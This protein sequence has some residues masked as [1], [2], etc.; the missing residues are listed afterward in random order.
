MNHRQKIREL[1]ADLRRKICV[2]ASLN[3]DEIFDASEFV[4]TAGAHLDLCLIAEHPDSGNLQNAAAVLEDDCI[5]FNNHLKKWYKAFCIAHEIGHFLLHHQSLHCTPEEIDSFIEGGETR[6]A[7]EKITGYGAGDRRER[8]A[9]LFALEL[10]LPSQALRKAYLEQ[11]LKAQKISALSGLPIEI[12]FGQLA[13]TALV[14]FAEKEELSAAAGKRELNPSQKQAAETAKCPTL[15]YA[16]PGTGKT[17]TLIARIAHLINRGTDPKRILALTFSNKAAEEMRERIEKIDRQAAAQ[18]QVMTFHAYG[19]DIL[20]AYWLEAGLDPHT[21]LV[22]KIDALLHLESNLTALKLDHYQNLHEPTQNLSAVLAAISRAKDELC[23]PENYLSLGEKMLAEA[24]GKGDEELSLKARKVIETAGVYR[25]Y[26]NYLRAEK[27]LDFGDLVYRAVRLL[28]SNERVKKE[29]QGKYDAVLVDEFQDVNRACGVLLKEIAGNGNSLWTVGDLRQSIYRWR[30]ASPANIERFGVDFPQAETISL[31]SNYRSRAEIVDLFSAFAGKMAAS[32]E[33]SFSAWESIRGAALSKTKKAVTLTIADSL[34][35]EAADIARQIENLHVEQGLR[36]KDC[37]VICRTHAQL[38][39]FAEVLSRQ[40]IPIFYLGELFEREEIRDLLALLDVKITPGSHSLIRVAAFPEY[41]IPLADA[42]RIIQA[43][44][45]NARTCAEALENTELFA[46]L[47]A[48]GRTGAAKLLHHLN[49][50]PNEVS[51]WKYLARYLF[52]ESEYLTTLFAAGEVNNQ[53]KR[54]AVYQFLRLAESADRRF[55]GDSKPPVRE[56]L[57]YVVKLAHFN[58]DKNYAQIPAEAENLDAVRL[59][60]VHSAKG[61]EFPAVFLPYLGAGKFPSKRNSQTCPN[62]DGMIEHDADFH[63]AEEECLFFVAMS[64]ARDYLHLSR[65]T[66][67][68]ES[69]SNESKFLK[70]LA[71]KLPAAALVETDDSTTEE[72]EISPTAEIAGSIFYAAELDRYNRCGRDYFY[73][74]VLG[75]KAAGEKSIY[76]KFH[77]CLYDTLRSMQSM[78]QLGNVGLNEQTALARLA[79][80]WQAAEVDL[81]AYAPIYK[82]RAEE[83]IRRMC[84]KMLKDVSAQEVMR[85]T[86]DVALSGGTIRVALDSVELADNYGEKTVIIRKFKTGKTPKKSDAEDIDVLMKAAAQNKFPD[87]EISLQKI[88][89][90]DDEVREIPISAKVT[91]NRLKNY[92]T[93]IAKIKQGI[94]AAQP[95]DNC[96]YCPHFFICP[97]G[98]MNG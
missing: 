39:K 19:L 81:H 58:E 50:A 30:G 7:A 36:Y 56:F 18:I 10:L 44:K 3:P 20:R 91:A 62:P 74:H 48:E 6:T 73:T 46:Q 33:Q 61:L 29:V 37:A 60:T 12:V 71:G 59:L 53:S 68:G 70:T 49:S 21:P 54:L 25:F 83:I 69:T 79:E 24:R 31:E 47:S 86:Y 57:D 65:S 84:A 95:G 14:P 94:F 41:K 15:V 13:R 2:S 45:D 4:E 90:S 64:R 27:L 1:A 78:M 66:K 72:A 43:Q 89:L 51:T 93:A 55:S 52:E 42:R 8:E 23:D 85:P 75:L 35:A 88:Y 77:S 96:P 67:Y 98:E 9:D 28:Q 92:E 34:A 11:G 63:E 82:I 87:A 16:G 17:Q 26:E 22:D 5:Y 32:G 97:S 76:L 80:F 38:N 40:G